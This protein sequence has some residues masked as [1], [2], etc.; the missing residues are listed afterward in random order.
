M[1]A[2]RNGPVIWRGFHEPTTSADIPQA[3]R[4][5]IH[6]AAAVRTLLLQLI[7]NLEG[8]PKAWGI[9]TRF[10]ALACFF[11]LTVKEVLTACSLLIDAHDLHDEQ[12]LKW[13]YY[14]LQTELWHSKPRL[15]SMRWSDIN[16]KDRKRLLRLQVHHDGF[17]LVD[18]LEWRRAVA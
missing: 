8:M 18:F 1:Q 6:Q 11:A 13:G 4:V 7:S 15:Q 10:S 12:C 5:Y 17:K 2:R 9:L 16:F 3:N 14:E